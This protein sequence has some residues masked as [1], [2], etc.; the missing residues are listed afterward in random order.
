MYWTLKGSRCKQL[1]ADTVPIL[2]AVSHVL[3]E[4]ETARSQNVQVQSINLHNVCNRISA[5][6]NGG[7]VNLSVC[8]RGSHWETRQRPP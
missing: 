3:A 8:S 5:S 4:T 6:N 2:H 7:V 1:D